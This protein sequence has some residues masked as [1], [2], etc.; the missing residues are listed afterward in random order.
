MN[1]PEYSCPKFDLLLDLVSKV[2]SLVLGDPEE[3]D[4]NLFE[5]YMNGLGEGIEDCRRANSDIREWGKE[6]HQEAEELRPERDTL[7]EQ[8]EELESER[9]A[10]LSQVQDLENEINSLQ[11]E[12]SS[13]TQD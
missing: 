12:L 4:N 5:A 8:V 7:Q 3:F 10:L 13:V 1:E 2:E 6:G 11:Q 9:D